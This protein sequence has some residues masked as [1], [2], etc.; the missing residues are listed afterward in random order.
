MVLNPAGNTYSPDYS[1]LYS[2]TYVASFNPAIPGF[3]EAGYGYLR[4]GG[5]NVK[6]GVRWGEIKGF[7]LAT[8]SQ[9]NWVLVWQEINKQLWNEP[10][11]DL[12]IGN[13]GRN[14]TTDSDLYYRSLYAP[15]AGWA[16]ATWGDRKAL[17]TKEV[18]TDCANLNPV[19]RTDKNGKWIAFW[20]TSNQTLE[21]DRSAASVDYH[22][23]PVKVSSYEDFDRLAV[24]YAE[25]TTEKLFQAPFP[26][27]EAPK[28][29]NKKAFIDSD[30]EF[31][32][33]AA[34][35]ANQN[36]VAVW[37]K[38]N[39]VMDCGEEKVSWVTHYATSND[40]GVTW[41]DS[42]RNCIFSSQ[43][44]PEKA[45][46]AHAIAT[47]GKGEFMVSWA[48]EDEKSYDT[49]F[50]DSFDLRYQKAYASSDNYGTL[51]THDYDIVTARTKGLL[52]EGTDLMPFATATPTP[53]PEPIPSVSREYKDNQNDPQN[54]GQLGF[55]TGLTG[56]DLVPFQAGSDYQIPATPDTEYQI[57][58]EDSSHWDIPGSG[59]TPYGVVAYFHMPLYPRNSDGSLTGTALDLPDD[60]RKINLTFTG[61]G[62]RPLR[63]QHLGL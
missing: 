54:Q 51:I 36:W 47:D 29:L 42:D 52:P 8:D 59:T 7:D 5:N 4:C 16:T 61:G 63:I 49:S 24:A 41:D 21:G 31:S 6:H 33:D 62:H 10:P 11:T 60:I 35:D 9:G 34:T 20:L 22:K 30:Y 18:G 27:W 12:M 17:Y 23:K 43:S 3:T 14:I 56:A 46:F 57:A 26:Y 19:I 32:I 39:L 13:V 15:S 1:Y 40:N 44:P 38:S 28:Y 2:K 53:T 25:T 45:E 37:A 55:S 58:H 48:A 50:N